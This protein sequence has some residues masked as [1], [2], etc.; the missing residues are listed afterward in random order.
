MIPELLDRHLSNLGL[1]MPTSFSDLALMRS[2]SLNISMPDVFQPT[3]AWLQ[4]RDF[5]VGRET[6]AEGHEKKHA[7]LL[8]PGII[9]SGLESWTTSEDHAQFFRQ[10]VRQGPLSVR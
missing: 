3:R 4:G 9:S 6:L 10:R 8:V 2:L 5:Q 7:V 1:E